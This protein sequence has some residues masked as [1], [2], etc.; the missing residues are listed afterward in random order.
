MAGLKGW[1]LVVEDGVTST[2]GLAADET[3]ARRAGEG[4]SPPTL[5]L[6]TYQPCALVGRFQT[7]E[8]ELRVDSCRE[9]G[10]PVGRRPTGGGAIVMGPEQLGVAWTL[11]GAEQDGYR[12]ARAM[13]ARFSEGLVAGLSPLGVSARFRGKNDLEVEGRKVAGLGVYRDKSG[14]VLYHASVLVDLDIAWML[15]LLSTPFE[16]ISDKTIA[17]V[18]QR[19]TTV[20]REAGRT[21]SLDEARDS[22]AEGFARVFDVRLE[23]GSYSDEELRET[24]VLERDKYATE[25]WIQQRIDMPDSFGTHKVK[26][27]AGLLEIRATLAGPTLKAVYVGGDFFASE[28]ALADLEGALRWHSSA[29]GAVRETVHRV[30]EQW[31]EGLSGLPETT[32]ADAV[33]A[34]AHTASGGQYGCFVNPQGSSRAG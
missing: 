8:N 3:N 7:L 11:P 21:V 30:Y 20:R 10:I 31:G 25:E 29:V 28:G 26:T 23:R 14:G 34:A 4:T 24:R 16:K 5:R 18:A 17:T 12:H 9:Q 6:Y 19:V 15:G 27:P 13:M 2:F 33:L 1:R 22:I 32:V